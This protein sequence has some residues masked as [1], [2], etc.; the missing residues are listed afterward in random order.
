M[1]FPITLYVSYP[2]SLEPIRASP[3]PTAAEHDGSLADDQEPERSAILRLE[4]P[5]TNAPNH[6]PGQISV[7]REN[8][9]VE[10]RLDDRK[11]RP[12]GC[13]LDLHRKKTRL[14]EFGWFAGASWER[15]G[16]DKR[17]TFDLRGSTH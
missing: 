3:G 2:T 1:T 12:A 11:A 15:L 10:R 9:D 16:Q 6:A 5:T 8:T 4:R 14:V 7:L 17:E 13:G